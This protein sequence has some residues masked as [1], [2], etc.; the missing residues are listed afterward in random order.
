MSV[1][2]TVDNLLAKEGSQLSGAGVDGAVV[3]GAAVLMYHMASEQA[4]GTA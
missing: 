1:L 4:R 3:D 2:T